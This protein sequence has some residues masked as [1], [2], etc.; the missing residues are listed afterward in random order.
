MDVLIYEEKESL[1][2]SLCSMIKE[3]GFNPILA[4]DRQI[5]QNRKVAIID[6]SGKESETYALE[7]RRNGC[8]IIGLYGTISDD[9][10]SDYHLEKPFNARDVLDALRSASYSLMHDNNLQTINKK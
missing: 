10:K 7:A 8:K 6:F 1:R 5:M 9:H 2:D 3:F 4:D